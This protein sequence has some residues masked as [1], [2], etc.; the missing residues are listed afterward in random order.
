[1]NRDIR[2]LLEEDSR[3]SKG[4]M[5][6]GHEDRFIQKLE[7]ELPIKKSNPFF[8]LKIAA[9]LVLFMGLGYT[10]YNEMDG[11]QVNPDVVETKD[12]RLNIQS[13]GDISPD[14]QKVENYYLANINMELAKMEYAPENM[15][16]INGY[17]KR[18]SDL[19]KEYER[20]NKELAENGP[21]VETVEALINNL[22]LRLNLLQRL[23]E[24][25][26]ELNNEQNENFI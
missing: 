4:E 25:L 15:E 7:E 22:K 20:L 3:L 12:N 13:L 23:K 6:E 16:L 11:N 2:E 19:N 10:I 14:L 24:Q 21:N 5:P 18:L 17:L 9:G 8:F 1:M 26:N